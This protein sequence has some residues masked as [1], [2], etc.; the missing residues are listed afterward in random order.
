MSTDLGP[1]IE[2]LRERSVRWGDFTLASGAKS[3]LYVDARQTT[4]HARGARLIAEAVLARLLPEVTAVGGPV[5]GADP[6][7]G[8]V[9]ALSSIHGREVHGFMV[10]KEPKGHGRMLWV[11]G[12][13]NL[14]AG[15]PVCVIE[16]TVTTGGSLLR[17]IENTEAS[18]L[19]VVQVLVVVDREEGA[20]ERV[21]AAGYPFE[22]LVRRRDLL[23]G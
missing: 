4:L 18:G 21:R 7:A 13:E 6:I 10:R 8:A 5:S 2:L 14:P 20:A 1:L 12:R 17:A 9:A 11:E 16:D 3:D 15:A 19:K 22:A 23:P